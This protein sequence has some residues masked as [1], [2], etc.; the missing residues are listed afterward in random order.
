MLRRRLIHSRR[1]RDPVAEPLPLGVVPREGLQHSGP[2][3]RVADWHV[4]TVD[5]VGDLLGHAADVGGDDGATVH[6]GFL[7]HHGRVLP[8]YRGHHNPVHPQHA[9]RE[10]R[11]LVGPDPAQH[12]VLLQRAAERHDPLPELGRLVVKIAAMDLELQ[13][14]SSGAGQGGEGRQQDV[15][16]LV[17]VDLP[18]EPEA[19]AALPVQKRAGGVPGG[20]DLP[21]LEH[22]DAVRR[23]PPVNVALPQ[24]GG[25]GDEV[26]DHA[27]DRRVAVLA[28]PEILDAAVGKAARAVVGG[29]ARTHA[30][31]VGLHHLSVLETD[32]HHLVQGQD[33]PRIGQGAADGGNDLEPEMG[34]V[35]QVDDGG[36]GARQEF[37]ELV[38]DAAGVGAGHLEPVGNPLL[39]QVFILAAGRQLAGHALPAVVAGQEPGPLD[40]GVP[41]ITLEQVVGRYFASAE[42][43]IGMAVG[44]DEY[45]VLCGTHVVGASSCRMCAQRS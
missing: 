13:A 25:G 26:V 29:F 37:G 2:G 39:P 24:E 3:E 9:F 32:R 44:N 31:G 6:E 22:G 1:Q 20:V 5:A 36:P 8:P 23:E 10:L 35:V 33:D 42:G 19:G 12:A 43:E 18:E 30:Q 17:G 34:V 15:D 41:A 14:F 40:G 16:A 27:E 7:D 11:R 4:A 28:K 38:H 21:V 45:A